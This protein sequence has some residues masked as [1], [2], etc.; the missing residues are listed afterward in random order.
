MGMPMNVIDSY[1]MLGC[2]ILVVTSFVLICK[3]DALSYIY[4]VNIANEKIEFI[5]LSFI[6]ISTLYFDN[7]DYVEETS[8]GYSYLFVF[9]FKNR[10][11]NTTFLINKKK[12]VFTKQL[13]I[14][15]ADA[16][17]FIDKLKSAGVKVILRNDV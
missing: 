12:G 5:L 9:N 13:L 14:T 16:K 4:D 2:L 3:F 8:G 6:K 15:P 11:F 10:F 1:Y 7:I 17:L